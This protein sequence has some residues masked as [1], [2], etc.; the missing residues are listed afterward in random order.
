LNIV[1]GISF[2]LL[3]LPSLGI[4]GVSIARGITMLLTFI[5]Y[6]W[7]LRRKI[8]LAFDRE[9]FW[10]SL[11]SSLVMIT[12]LIVI[13]NIWSNAYLLPIYM[14]LGALVYIVMLRTLKAVRQS[15]V[16][17]MKLY[18]GKRLEFLVKP[19]EAILLG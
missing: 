12:P 6:M 3:L 19:F 13:Q 1:F 2:G 10:K 11:V 15:D 18:L 16:D 8:N 4:V 9:A 17:L 5:M 14:G 7:I